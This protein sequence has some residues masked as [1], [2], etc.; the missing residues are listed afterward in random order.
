MS[1]LIPRLV[2]AISITASA[3]TANVNGQQTNA[4][5]D[6]SAQNN[7]PSRMLSG[8]VP[9]QPAPDVSTSPRF[10]SSARIKMMLDNSVTRDNRS[11]DLPQTSRRRA[12]NAQQSA[13]AVDPIRLASYEA[14]LSPSLNQIQRTPP[15][16]CLSLIHI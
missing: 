12:S 3:W 9:K 4:F 13:P 1:S 11:N 15:P 6:N 14:D 10:G 8:V 16:P 7:G 5:R 2:F